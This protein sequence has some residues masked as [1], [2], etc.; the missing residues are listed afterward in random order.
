MLRALAILALTLTPAM[1]DE[2]SNNL[3]MTRSAF[4]ES[5]AE[6]YPD[7]ELPALECGRTTVLRTCTSEDWLKIQFQATDIYASDDLLPVFIAGAQGKLFSL[8]LQAD[9]AGGERTIETFSRYCAAL[10]ERA[11]PAWTFADAA[12]ML[13]TM[14]ETAT[15]EAEVYLADTSAIY[16]VELALDRLGVCE[17]TAEHTL[18]DGRTVT[19]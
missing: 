14:F 13:E 5:F 2:P 12:S 11:N 19:N 6:T 16:T 3:G 8:K 7:L 1:A 15:T 18:P 9:L 17:V 4:L 10:F